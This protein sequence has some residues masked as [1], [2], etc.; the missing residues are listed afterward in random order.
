VTA[1]ALDPFQ[2]IVGVGWGG[3]KTI[4]AIHVSAEI[5][6][7]VNGPLPDST[8]SVILSIGTSGGDI[9]KGSPLVIARP[10][11]IILPPPIDQVV[12]PAMLQHYAIWSYP[13]FFFDGPVDHQTV[14]AFYYISTDVATFPDFVFSPYD[15]VAAA[16]AYISAQ[17]LIHP[18]YVGQLFIINLQPGYEINRRTRRWGALTFINLAAFPSATGVLDFTLAGHGSDVLL[19]IAV[20]LYRGTDFDFTADAENAPNFDAQR[21]AS[22]SYRARPGFSATVSLAIRA[23]PRVPSVTGP[24]SPG[25]GGGDG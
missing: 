16:Q 6:D 25:G 5:T 2:T 11:S 17:A 1:I 7:D 4:V 15:S 10:G 13:P 12:T 23:D 14:P 8:Y 22:Y 19:E 18:E 9:L 20:G 21:I 24:A 3:D